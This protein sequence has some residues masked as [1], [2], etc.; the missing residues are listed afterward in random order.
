MASTGPSLV[1]S[2]PQVAEAVA[3]SRVAI[4]GGKAKLLP[5]C[6][7]SAQAPSNIIDVINDPSSI[8]DPPQDVSLVQSKRVYMTRSK[9]LFA[10][11]LPIPSATSLDV[12][13]T[14]GRRPGRSRQGAASQPPKLPSL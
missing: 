4:R 3:G 13:D 9:S 14:A 12:V 7:Q 5:K 8:E 6:S 2:R 1:A 10:S 11:I